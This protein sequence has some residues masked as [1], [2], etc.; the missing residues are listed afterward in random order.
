MEDK[1]DGSSVQITTK[2]LDLYDKV[3]DAYFRKHEIGVFAYDLPCQHIHTKNIELQCRS[4]DE[5]A[6]TKFICLD[7]NTFI[8]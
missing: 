7:C 2:A 3:I 5:L 1:E 8:Q 4:A 6:A